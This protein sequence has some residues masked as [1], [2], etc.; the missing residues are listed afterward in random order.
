MTLTD[1]MGCALGAAMAFL[2]GCVI[3]WAW[4]RHSDGK[5]PIHRKVYEDCRCEWMPDGGD[6]YLRL[7]NV[8]LTCPIHGNGRKPHAH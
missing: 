1:T 2:A 5:R 4:I 3:T 8:D 7:A 6:R